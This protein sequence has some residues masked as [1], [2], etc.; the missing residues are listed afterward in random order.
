MKYSKYGDVS[1]LLTELCC[2]FNDK[3]LT[4]IAELGAKMA[5]DHNFERAYTLAVKNLYVRNAT[6]LQNRSYIP[7]RFEELNKEVCQK[8]AT[9]SKE[10]MATLLPDYANFDSKEKDRAA[11]KDEIRAQIIKL[12]NKNK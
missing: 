3:E 1:A 12:K 11:L 2:T 9:S 4:L 5:N 6:A 8:I 7:K 10:N